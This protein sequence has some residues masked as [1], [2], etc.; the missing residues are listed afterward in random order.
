M[1]KYWLY[2]RED[3]RVGAESL[4]T[5]SMTFRRKSCYS[6]EALK[7]LVVPGT[8]R[9]EVWDLTD[10]QVAKITSDVSKLY[11][12]QHPIRVGI[13]AINQDPSGDPLGKILTMMPLSAAHERGY[14][15]MSSPDPVETLA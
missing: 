13:F 8:I 6:G 1:A 11:I 10:E 5:P 9:G 7:Y 4:D 14:L 2:M 3:R 12:N 15:Q